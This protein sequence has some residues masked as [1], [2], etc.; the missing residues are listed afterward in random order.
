MKS[1]I[2][3]WLKDT[4]ERA[5]FTFVEAFIG[6]LIVAESGSVDGL[7]LS[8]VQTAGVSAFIS[9]LAVVK[10]AVASYRDGLSPA[11][12]ARLDGE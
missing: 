10:G 5:L 8:V 3:H 1:D 9:A 7:S 12:F 11:S 2:T 4:L 6:L